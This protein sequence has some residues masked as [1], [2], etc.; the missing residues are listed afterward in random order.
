MTAA[1]SIVIPAY[2]GKVHLEANLPHLLAATRGRAS[3]EVTVVDDGSADGT[4]E[5][6]ADRY[7]EVRL[8][9]LGTNRGFAGACNAGA[10]AAK[11][12][13]VYFLNSDVRVL[14]GFLDPVLTRFS[15]PTVFAAGSR[16]VPPQGEGPLTVPVPFFRFGLFGHRYLETAGT[17]TQAMP[18]LFVSAGHALFSRERFLSLGGFDDLY[19]PFYWEDIDL[20]FRAWRRGW[21]V[22]LEPGST[23][24]HGK[25]GTIG[26]FYDPQA[27]QTI[28][29]KN[30]FLFIWKNLRDAGL[31][32]E[33]L[34]CLPLILLAFPLAKGRAVLTG[35]ARAF[36]QLGEVLGK[37]RQTAGSP[38]LSDREILKMFSGRA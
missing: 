7:P 12:D 1:V 5:F 30:R 27:I 26:R 33:H 2:N 17:R 9:A 31:V 28:Y 36:R 29:W 19:R 34:A 35:F 20:C 38:A 22:L 13:L 6:L 16:E 8:V 18:V 15:D 4:P 11:G 21:R 25:Q 23:V 37:R 10:Q 14:P 3:L 24:V 32:A